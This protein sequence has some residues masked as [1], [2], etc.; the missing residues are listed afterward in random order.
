[1]KNLLIL[2][3]TLLVFA[4]IG[5]GLAKIFKVPSVMKS[6]E[7]VGVKP[8]Q[9]QLLA[10]LEIL[11]GTGLVVGIWLTPLGELS[12]LCLTLYFIGAVGS[13]LKAKHG[14]SEIAPA[15]LIALISFFE[16]ILQFGR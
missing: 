14:F 4:S 3:G 2:L 9:V 13:H 10:L 16:T 8:N 11:G 6:M 12:A 15:F 1:M 7:S 5:S